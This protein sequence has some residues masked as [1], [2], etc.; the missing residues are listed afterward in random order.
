MISL[1]ESY[2]EQKIIQ[3]IFEESRFVENGWKTH[4]D[5]PVCIKLAHAT[6]Y[7]GRAKN[8]ELPYLAIQGI[9]KRQEIQISYCPSL[10]T[11]SDIMMKSL[12]RQE[13]NHSVIRLSLVDLK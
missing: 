13:H 1:V 10:E 6:G 11:L 4:C 8:I 9:V 5:N 2:K 3:K 7:S 12:S